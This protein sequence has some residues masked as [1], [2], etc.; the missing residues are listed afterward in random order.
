MPAGSLRLRLAWVV[1]PDQARLPS[2]S[3][4]ITST[5]LPRNAEDNCSAEPQLILHVCCGIWELRSNPIGL[6]RPHSEWPSD[7]KI[8]IASY[9]KSEDVGAGCS[10]SGL[11]EEAVPTVRVTGQTLSEHGDLAASAVPNVGRPHGCGEP[12]RSIPEF[13]I[14]DAFDP[15][16][17]RA[18]QRPR[19]TSAEARPCLPA[20]KRSLPE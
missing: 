5:G 17:F 8:D 3:Y 4:D 6:D 13:R 10:S 18:S 16:M 19:Q 20:A 1:K 15:E 11:G 12:I 7:S 14:L 2:H 9:L